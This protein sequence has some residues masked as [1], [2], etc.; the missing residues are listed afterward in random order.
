MSKYGAEKINI[1][2]INFD[3][4]IEGK[5]YEKCKEDKAKGLI[6]NFELQP[7][8]I[9]QPKY[10]NAEGKNIRAIILKAD[11]LIYEINGTETVIDI[12]GMATAEALMKRKMFGY[13]HPKEKLLWIVR[14]GGQWI[15]YDENKKGVAK[16]K[17]ERVA[18]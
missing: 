16:R 4:K 8:Y 5:Y 1:D 9:I 10:T 12:K 3:S 14:Y 6:L 17:K 13:T 2:G 15:G 11:F 18:K 7:K